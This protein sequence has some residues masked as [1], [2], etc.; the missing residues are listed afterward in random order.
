VQI[1]SV[2]S[3]NPDLQ[4][5]KSTS[6]TAGII[7]EPNQNFSVGLNY[8]QIEWKNQ[9]SLPSVT[10]TLA[11]GD[12]AHVIRD[13][14]TGDLRTVIRNYI[15]LSETKTNGVD[16]DARY[17]MSTSVG[18]W[19]ARV[20]V[21]Y[22]DSFKEEGTE[23]AGT[24]GGSNTIP[25]TRGNLALDWDHQALAVTAQ[26]NYIRSYYQ[27]SLPSS[28]FTPPTDLNFQNG[29]YPDRIP[30][31]VTYD[32][33]ARYN[34]NKNLAISGSIININ[35]KKPPYDPVFTELYDWS[36]YDVRGRQFR[37]GLTYKM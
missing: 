20:N 8:Y 22:V 12:P 18:R 36:V 10:D 1:S 11:A 28:W 7:W 13:P 23:Y 32:M 35:D 21:S 26:V 25:R 9:V 2:R 30:T 5:E 24:N 31:R 15:N 34:I 14:A 37:I 3:G 17:R 6:A 33:Y 4:P 29:L 16:L 27:Q 19:T